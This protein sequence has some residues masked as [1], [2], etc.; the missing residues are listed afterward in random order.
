M[1]EIIQGG[2]HYSKFSLA[3]KKENDDLYEIIDHKNLFY[4]NGMS[5]SSTSS[6]FE[7]KYNPQKKLPWTPEEKCR[8][9]FF[10]RDILKSEDLIEENKMYCKVKPN[11]PKTVKKL[12]QGYYEFTDNQKTY[13]QEFH[14]YGRSDKVILA[15]ESEAKDIS[16]AVFE[17]LNKFHKK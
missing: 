12:Y 14:P 11:E 3:W 4:T 10:Q 1:L 15:D 7:Q 6:L 17:K 16:N 8:N 2:K 5:S 13:P 9:S